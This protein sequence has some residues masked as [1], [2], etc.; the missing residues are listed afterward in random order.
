MPSNVASVPEPTP[1][2]KPQ[3]FEVGLYRLAVGP[4]LDIRHQ[5][6]LLTQLY[7]EFPT[8]KQIP[9]GAQFIDEYKG[10]MLTFDASKMEAIDQQPESFVS[11][12]AWMRTSLEKGLGAIAF[13]PPFR[14]KVTMRGAIQMMGDLDASA[15]LNRRFGA[16]SAWFDGTGEPKAAVRY[17]VEHGDGAAGDLRI[18]PLFANPK[19][20]FI[21]A[22]S[23]SAPSAGYDSL[24]DAVSFAQK[25]AEQ[26]RERV[27][28]IIQDLVKEK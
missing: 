1:P 17:V 8:L 19:N 23:Y 20:F 28:R 22:T 3:Y 14:V 21:E 25:E 7:T 10:R 24:A 27:E 4:T 15:I 26:A 16:D 12:A 18:E 2:F 11:A 13:K 9:G 6:E 5:R